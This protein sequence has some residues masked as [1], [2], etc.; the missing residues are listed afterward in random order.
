MPIL[1]GRTGIVNNDRNEINAQRDILYE[2]LEL[3]AAATT[4]HYINSTL[5]HI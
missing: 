3:V 2:Q 5:G 4:V 1:K